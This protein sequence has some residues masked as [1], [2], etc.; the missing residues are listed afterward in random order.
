MPI[1][2]P[3][4]GPD[5]LYPSP[6]RGVTWVTS[7]FPGQ[8]KAL[9]HDASGQLLAEV[10]LCERLATNDIEQRMLAWI[11]IVDPLAAPPPVLTLLR[12]A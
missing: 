10:V 3:T 12:E 2:S 11:D 6:Y 5:G 1:S 8:M 7:H 4:V 9:L